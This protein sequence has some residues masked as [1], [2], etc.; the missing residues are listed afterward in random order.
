MQAFQQIK[1]KVMNRL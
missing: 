1:E